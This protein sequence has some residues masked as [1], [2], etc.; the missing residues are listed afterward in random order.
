MKITKILDIPGSF[1][2]DFLDMDIDMNAEKGLGLGKIF[3]PNESLTSMG[4][5]VLTLASG[6]R[7][8]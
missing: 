1:F 2:F 6:I 3:G 4:I 8:L 7:Q 5:L